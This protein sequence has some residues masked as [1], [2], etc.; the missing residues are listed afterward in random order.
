MLPDCR[1]QEHTYPVPKFELVEKEVRSFAEELKAFHDEFGE[2]FRRSETKENSFLYLSGLFGALE[3]KSIEPIAIH[4]ESG[5]VRSMQR[6]ISETPWDTSGMI[7]KYRSMACEDLSDPRG[8]LIFDE[9]GFAKKGSESAGVGRQYCGNLGKVENCQVG[10]FAA[11]AGPHGYAV[12]DKQL[13]LPEDWFT[14]AYEKRWDKC[15]IPEDI[16]FK[17][18]PQIAADMLKTLRDEH[19]LPFKYVLADSI[20]GTS[21]EFIQAVDADP[22]LTYFV[23]IPSNTLF[24]PHRPLTE[25]KKYRYKGEWHEKTVLN[26]RVSKPI[27][28]DMFASN[29]HDAFWYRRI[30]SEGTKGPV[31]YEFSKRRVILAK[32]GLPHKE[33]WLVIKRTLGA[34]HDYSFFISNAARSTRLETF[35]WLSGM[36]WPIEQCFEEMKSELG[37][38]HYEMRKYRGWNQHMLLVMLAHFFLWHLKIRLGKKSACAYF[39][40]A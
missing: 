32:E 9:S 38:D 35:V 36:R 37:M 27:R 39:V 23:A 31:T 8:V 2:Y 12:V 7:K 3:R 15:E 24:W 30:V 21:P 10:V 5:D 13:Y 16:S 34:E 20:Y 14:D 1:S 40:A 19:L 6:A 18:K 22:L 28:V 29:L 25:T 11:Y 26:T 33:V 4:S 17:S